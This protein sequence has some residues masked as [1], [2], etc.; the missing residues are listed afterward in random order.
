MCGG[1]AADDGVGAALPGTRLERA[2]SSRPDGSAYSVRSSTGSEVRETPPGG[3][4]PRR[5]GRT[6]KRPKP[7]LGASAAKASRVAAQPVAA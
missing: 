2:V 1:F 6:P 7:A 5:C 4:L 3:H